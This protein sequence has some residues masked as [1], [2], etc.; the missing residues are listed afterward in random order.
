LNLIRVASKDLPK[1]K[2]TLLKET[3]AQNKDN[4]TITQ[5]ALSELLQ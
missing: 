1:N 2:E 3:L 5:K 4:P